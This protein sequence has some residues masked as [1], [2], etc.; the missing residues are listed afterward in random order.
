MESPETTTANLA[1]LPAEAAL[2]RLLDEHGGRL[3]GLAL[4]FC[5]TPE[6]AEDLVQETFLLAFRNWHQFQGDSSPTTWLYTIASRACQ[7]RQRRR[8]GEPRTLDPLADVA[9]AD[10]ATVATVDPSP[11]DEQLR[12]EARESV[13]RAISEL[14]HHYRMP[15][16][17]KEIVEL[18]VAE[19]AAILGLKEA[20]VKTRVHRG[21]LHLRRILARQ[22]ERKT[23]AETHQDQQICLDL[24][25]SKQEALDRG[26]DFPVPQEE[27]CDRC[28][29]LFKT[30]DLARQSCLDIGR[31]DLPPSLTARLR[32][33]LEAT[34]RVD[35]AN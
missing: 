2:P 31:G 8:S 11:L 18:S 9:A 17:L 23:T 25:R 27:I 13:E 3:Y 26:A 12:R 29:S 30:L 20:T 35:S 22:Q 7:R 6:D 10:E 28:R 24:L 19:V 33:E 15:L 16:V 34:P 21:R 32:E 1:E 5:G 14:P 4:R